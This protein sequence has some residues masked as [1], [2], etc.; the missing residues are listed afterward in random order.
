MARPTTTPSYSDSDA[1][2]LGRARMGLHH[3]A[4]PQ[5]TTN[6]PTRH[7]G[8]HC[9]PV[10]NPATTRPHAPDQMRRA[11]EPIWMHNSDVTTRALKRTRKA[12]SATTTSAQ[13]QNISASRRL[14]VTLK[15]NSRQ[16]PLPA[17]Q[18]TSSHRCRL[19]LSTYQ[20][21]SPSSPSTHFTLNPPIRLN[22][23]RSTVLV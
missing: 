10:Q 13:Y 14:P 15:I 8:P 18:Q 11:T 20:N 16:H 5:P 23:P 9:Q 6:L 22:A 21:L 17:K 7:N 1:R 2:S 19:G 4:T 12:T 3:L